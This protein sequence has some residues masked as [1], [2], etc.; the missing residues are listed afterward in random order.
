[1]VG[2]VAIT[3][4]VG[5]PIGAAIGA[6]FVG[7]LVNVASLAGLSYSLQ[8]VVEGVLVFAVVV[9]AGVVSREGRLRR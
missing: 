8:R 2:G 5:T 3:G 9:L 1:V 4:G 7:L 6:V